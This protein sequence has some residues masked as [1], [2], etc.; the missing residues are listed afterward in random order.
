M[1]TRWVHDMKVGRKG[2]HLQVNLLAK[3]L[4]LLLMMMMMKMRI[5]EE[6]HC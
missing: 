6:D 2:G 3:T 4:L 1:G 5:N